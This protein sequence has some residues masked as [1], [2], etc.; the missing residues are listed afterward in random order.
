MENSE[1]PCVASLLISREL[2]NVE[3]LREY[4]NGLNPTKEAASLEKGK[5]LLY[6]AFICLDAALGCFMYYEKKENQNET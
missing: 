4:V 6:Q 3:N 1:R 2:E 5:D